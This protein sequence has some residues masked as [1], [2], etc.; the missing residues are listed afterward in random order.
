MARHG[1][2]VG[3]SYRLVTAEGEFVATVRPMLPME[4]G[5][6]VMWGERFFMQTDEYTYSETRVDVVVGG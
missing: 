6:V 5:P 1:R 3:H 4:P 2:I